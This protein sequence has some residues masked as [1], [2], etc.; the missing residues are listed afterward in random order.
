MSV[1]LKVN[2]LNLG[3]SD[4]MREARRQLT[5]SQLRATVGPLLRMQTRDHLKNLP[6]NKKGWPSTGFWED[7]ARATRWEAEGDAVRIVVDKIGV[8][9]RYLGGPITPQVKGALTIPISPIAYGKTVADFP[10]S[11]LMKTPKGAY[12]VMYAN[13]GVN[14]GRAFKP[15]ARRR[16]ALH[17]LRATLIFLFKLSG[18]VNQK[19]DPNVLPTSAEYRATVFAAVRERLAGIKM[20]SG[21]VKA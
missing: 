10:G 14:K 11:F 9:Q 18:G 20:K 3:M 2:V 12:I 19:P 16:R 13:E 15:E 4:A 1:A 6:G 8:R 17:A 5:P 7:A 21:G